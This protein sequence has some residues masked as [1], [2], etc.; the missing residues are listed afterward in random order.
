M[1]A[2]RKLYSRWNPVSAGLRFFRGD[3]RE[4]GTEVRFSR[5]ARLSS[6]TV[7]S[8]TKFGFSPIFLS[9]L[10]KSELS[11]A[12]WWAAVT[13]IWLPPNISRTADSLPASKPP[14]QF[15]AGLTLISVNIFA[16]NSWKRYSDINPPGRR[17]F[18]VNVK[19]WPC[20]N[21]LTQAFVNVN[22]WSV[23]YPQLA[24]LT[25]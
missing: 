14:A 25:P 2:G 19:G 9:K 23:D 17:Q 10:G 21:R 7:A 22:F 3:G 13:G 20:N 5:C 1:G 24:L 6:T 11:L 4:G 18:S 15:L 16:A 8:L 12:I